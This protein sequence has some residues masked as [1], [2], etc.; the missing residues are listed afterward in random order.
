M[1]VN[2]EQLSKILV[3]A[4]SRVRLLGVVAL[5]ADW[6]ALAKK[7]AGTLKGNPDF[8]ITILCESDN[9]L[10]SKSFTCDTDVARNRRS[11]RELKFIRDR[12]TVD[13]PE[14]LLEERVPRGSIE[15]EIAHV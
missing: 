1:T 11:F 3:D 2:R 14:L 8:E 6:E 13:L 9:M 12:A 15:I 7:W 4:K 10:F 5:D